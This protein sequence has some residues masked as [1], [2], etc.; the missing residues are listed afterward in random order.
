M[1]IFLFL[2]QVAMAA[3]IAFFIWRILTALRDGELKAQQGL[4][5]LSDQPVLFGALLVL[6]ILA[7]FLCALIFAGTIV[8]YSDREDFPALLGAGVMTVAAMAWVAVFMGIKLG[9]VPTRWEMV[10]QT[11]SPVWYWTL[12]CSY[13]TFAIGFTALGL[14]ILSKVPL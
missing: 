13:I 4:V 11:K 5:R 6:H 3:F 2:F 14:R 12:F 10:D 9:V 8:G 7:T 1:G